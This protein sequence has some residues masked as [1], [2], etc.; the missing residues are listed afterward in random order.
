[1]M[2]ILTDV[3]HPKVGNGAFLLLKIPSIP[4]VSQ[5]VDLANRLNLT[6]LNS[7]TRSRCFGAWCKDVENKDPLDGIAYVCFIPSLAKKDRLLENE[8][9]QM[10]TR[11]RWLHEYL[12]LPDTGPDDMPSRLI[13]MERIK[14]EFKKS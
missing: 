14:K 13:A 1:M 2:R 9:Y 8:V 11:A 4:G 7:W 3:T 12:Q 10:A 6:E 5:N